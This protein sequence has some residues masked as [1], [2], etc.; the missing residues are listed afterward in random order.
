MAAPLAAQRGGGGGGAGGG[1]GAPAMIADPTPFEVFVDKMKLDGS[2]ID[3]TAKIF[4]AGAAEAKPV[5]DEMLQLRQKLLAAEEAGKTD[6]INATLTA[7]SAAA[8]KM[9][10]LEVKAFQQVQGILK[11]GQLGKSADG[12]AVIA[13]M[14]HPPAPRSGGNSRRGGGGE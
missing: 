1:S 3:Q 8:A 7:Y 12:F 2:Q 14:F 11:S 4:Q 9:T 6:E 10:G 13:G 5:A